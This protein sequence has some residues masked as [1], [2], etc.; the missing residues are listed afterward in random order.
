MNFGFTE[1]QEL[2]RDQIRKFLDTKCPLTEVRKISKTKQGHSDELWGEMAELGWLGLLIPEEYGGVGLGW[3]DLIVLMEETGRFLYPSPLISHSLCAMALIE[4]GNDT[5][6]QKWL[7]QLASGK[8]IGAIAL[9]EEDERYDSLGIQLAAEIN[10]ASVSLSGSKHYVSDVAEANLV[11]CACRTGAAEGDVS[12]VLVETVDDGV[13]NK[14]ATT[15]DATKREGVLTLDNVTVATDAVLGAVNQAWPAIERLNDCGAV[16][17]TAEAVGAAEQA[18]QITTN[19]AKERIQFDNQIGKYQSVKHPLAKMYVDIESFKSLS[20]F[21]AWNINE[22]PEDLP[23]SVSLAK[24]YAADVLPQLGI[25]C[26]GLHGAI[27]YTAEYD[28]QLYLKR[29]KWIRPKFGDAD[30]HFD[31][32]IN[33]GGVE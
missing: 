32:V 24:G 19:Y 14:A 6:K 12:L 29:T 2:L 28:I 23:R 15:M 33:L 3:I 11:V 27:G 13:T 5:Q 21:A 20:Y 9:Q 8:I 18:L 31:R 17:V 1:E 26:L 25:D 22:S 7:P 4:N 16:A 30:Y 10:G